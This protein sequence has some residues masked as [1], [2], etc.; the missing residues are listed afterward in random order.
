MM[1]GT[2]PETGAALGPDGQP[3]TVAA[4]GGEATLLGKDSWQWMLLGPMA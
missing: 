2:D 1:T 3:I 4:N